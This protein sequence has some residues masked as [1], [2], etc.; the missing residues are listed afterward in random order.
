MMLGWCD[1]G[2]MSRGNANSRVWTNKQKKC[3]GYLKLNIW[4]I[5]KTVWQNLIWFPN[6][7]PSFR[8]FFHYFNWNNT[9]QIGLTIKINK[10]YFIQSIC[11]FI[12]QTFLPYA[13]VF[14]FCLLALHLSPSHSLR[15]PLIMCIHDWV[16][17]NLY[18]FLC[19][20]TFPLCE[21][22]IEI[23]MR[24]WNQTRPFMNAYR[25]FI[26]INLAS[27]QLQTSTWLQITD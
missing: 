5:Q 20:F 2:M 26:V 19:R 10:H 14:F 3:A 7:F 1:V 6:L 16:D 4:S 18:T 25:K 21:Y 22:W 15:L 8:S 11:N 17:A 24:V 13:L 27:I 12:F 23:Y 9:H